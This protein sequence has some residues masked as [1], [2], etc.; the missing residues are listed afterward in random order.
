MEDSFIKNYYWYTLFQTFLNFYISQSFTKSFFLF[1]TVN[2]SV[3][4]ALSGF[5]T[6]HTHLYVYMLVH[7]PFC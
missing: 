5:N 2:V 3:T 6:A 7:V 4:Q 1:P